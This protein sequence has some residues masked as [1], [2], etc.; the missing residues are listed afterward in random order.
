MAVE[1]K[2]RL[3]RSLGMSLSATVCFTHPT[4]S[5]LGR[6][7]ATKLGLDGEPDARPPALDMAP[8][9]AG[10]FDGLSEAELV[11]RI[12]ER[13]DGVAGETA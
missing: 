9:D 11:S 3:E 8:S 10:R 12:R 6:L 7:L 13:L 5:A 4:V 2:H 1:L